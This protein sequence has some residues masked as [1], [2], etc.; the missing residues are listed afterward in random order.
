[1]PERDRCQSESGEEEKERERERQKEEEGGREEERKYENLGD[2]ST[3]TVETQINDLE[4]QVKGHSK[5]QSKY[6]NFTM[7]NTKGLK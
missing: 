7:S 1:M 2:L 5:S 3:Y 4:D 6:P